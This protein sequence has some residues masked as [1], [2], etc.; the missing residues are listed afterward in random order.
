[1]SGAL[2]VLMLTGSSEQALVT[3]AVGLGVFGYLIKP[4]RT[5]L[6]FARIEE[7]I[8]RAP[9]DDPAPGA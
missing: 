1:L 3:A 7:V 5:E 8:G 4:V 9:A 6:L 2:P